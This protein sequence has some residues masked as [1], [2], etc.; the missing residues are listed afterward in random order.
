M[1]QYWG[2]NH[3]SC[4]YSQTDEN[5]G[6]FSYNLRG[7]YFLQLLFSP[8]YAAAGEAEWRLQQ[9]SMLERTSLTLLRR[10]NQAVENDNQTRQEIMSLRSE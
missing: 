8:Q 7:I 6:V 5:K 9:M 2:L 1:K 3:D 4:S 10:G